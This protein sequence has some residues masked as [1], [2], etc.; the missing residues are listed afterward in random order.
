MT[1]QFDL[2]GHV[3]VVTGGNAGLGLG[4]AR[5]LARAGASI[6]VWGRNE[7]RNAAAVAEMR[8]LGVEAEGFACDVTNPAAVDAAMEATVAR[9]GKVD[10]LFANAG[11]SGARKPFVEMTPADWDA[12]QRLNVDSVVSSFRAAARQFM[13]QG[14]GGKLVVTSSIAALL[15]LPGGPYSTS[16]AAVSGMVRALAVELAP[17]GIR[18]NAILPGF[19]ETEMSLNTPKAF[20]DACLRRTPSGKL[21]TIDDMGGIAVFLASRASDLV[22]GQSIVIDGGQS[23]YPF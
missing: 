14:S 10:S 5:G 17:A 15:G 12:V 21:G 6:A 11:G 2:T 9:F 18:V 19:I 3:S 16:K 8:E 13:A 20:R 7:G 22:T 23:I 4:M 1:G